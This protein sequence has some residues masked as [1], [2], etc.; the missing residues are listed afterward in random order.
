MNRRVLGV[1]VGVVCI[2]LGSCSTIV[3]GTNQVVSVNTPGVPGAMCTLQSPAIGTRSVKT[4]GTIKLPKSRHDVVVNCTAQC[5]KGTGM[6]ASGTEMMTAGNV[7][8]GGVIGLGVDAASG[9]MNKYEPGVEVSMSRI[10][11]CGGSPRRGP[12]VSS[13]PAP[14]QRG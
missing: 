12:S 6:L 10:P 13:L 8:L 2:F 4:P 3:K 1:A 7:F 5:F 11:G 14:A 9:A